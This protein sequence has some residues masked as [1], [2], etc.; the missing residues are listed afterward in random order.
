MD[1]LYELFLICCTVHLSKYIPIPNSSLTVVC[2]MFLEGDVKG[3]CSDNEYKLHDVLSR[4]SINN[5]SAP[6]RRMFLRQLC[7]AQVIICTTFESERGNRG[8]GTFAVAKET[9]PQTG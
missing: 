1:L 4:Q 3:I 9:W 7:E 6:V 5:K 2:Q 8:Y